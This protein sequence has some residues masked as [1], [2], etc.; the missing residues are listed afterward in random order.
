MGR[1]RILTDEQRLIN[2]R[3]NT[4]KWKKNNPERQAFLNK[5][6]YFKFKYGLQW[7]QYLKLLEGG[8][9][10]CGTKK[11]LNIDHDHDKPGTYRGVLCTKHNVMLG[12]LGDKLET[13]PVVAKQCEDYLRRAA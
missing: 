10:I 13:I 4:K 8:C 7:D 3:E 9:A 12:M 11:N 2:R 5:K 6:S 1:K